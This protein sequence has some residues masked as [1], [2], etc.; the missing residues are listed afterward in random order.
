MYLFY[1]SYMLRHLFNIL[2][3]HYILYYYYAF[4]YSFFTS[5]PTITLVPRYVPPIQL[6]RCF[7][8]LYLAYIQ[9]PTLCYFSYFFMLS[10]FIIYFYFYFYLWCYFIFIFHIFIYS[11]HYTNI[12]LQSYYSFF[13]FRETYP[14]YREKVTILDALYSS[15]S[16]QIYYPILFLERHIFI[17]QRER[18]YD[19]RTLLIHFSPNLLYNSILRKNYIH[20]IERNF[21][22]LLVSTSSISLQSYYSFFIFRET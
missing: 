6:Y 22:Y 21:I 14:F 8:V 9:A 10:L 2:F 16:L 3:I 1:V 19:G 5:I 15:I 17:L 12:S 4:S 20:S 13:I 11:T 18:Y 7:A